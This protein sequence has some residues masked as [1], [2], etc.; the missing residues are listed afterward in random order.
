MKLYFVL[1]DRFSPLEVVSQGA[2]V[3]TGLLPL[4]PPWESLVLPE[5]A[6]NIEIIRCWCLRRPRQSVGISIMELTVWLS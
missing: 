1:H 3:S 5:Q 2:G 4:V 6:A